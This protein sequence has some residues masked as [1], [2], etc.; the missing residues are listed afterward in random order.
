MS[1]RTILQNRKCGKRDGGISI[2]EQKKNRNGK[3]NARDVGE[4]DMSEIATVEVL[5]AEV[6]ALMVGSRQVTLSV[7]RQLDW[8]TIEEIKIFGRVNDEKELRHLPRD[9]LCVV[10]AD[11]HGNLCRAYAFRPEE[12]L[13]ATVE[14]D[15]TVTRYAEIKGRN[16]SH[17]YN[18]K[19]FPVMIS[20]ERE[21]S[22]S[23]K[24]TEELMDKIRTELDKQAAECLEAM[25]LYNW[26]KNAPLIVLAGLK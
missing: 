16:Y 4:N 8:M 24:F 25:A 21:Y 10:G 20:D 18:G 11:K 14:K 23:Y 15:S 1:A 2:P 3:S 7:F 12:R 5:T 17:V 26:V 9:T 13:I 22:V 19:R 6:K